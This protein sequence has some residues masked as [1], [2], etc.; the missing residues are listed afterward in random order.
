MKRIIL[1]R[2]CGDV[3]SATAH[4]LFTA[5]YA[6]VI[7]DSTQPAT[8]R[9]KMAFCDAVF[10]GTAEVD[11]V[12]AKLCN[13]VSELNVRLAAHD[14][15]TVT[16]LD[17]S[18]VLAALKP[19][20]LVDARMRKHE[21]P[22]VQITLAPFT[23]GLGPNFFAGTTDNSWAFGCHWDRRYIHLDRGRVWSRR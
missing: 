9:R 20:V 8:T 16:T 5:G 18:E 10:D 6:V 13:D 22:E 17:L 2:G 7:H 1:I 4:I 15:V 11:G 3:A 23:V 21:Q 12:F 14:T 19:E